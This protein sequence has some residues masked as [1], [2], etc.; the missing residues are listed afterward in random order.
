MLH[1]VCD[2][3]ATWMESSLEDGAIRLERSTQEVLKALD[4]CE[5]VFDPL[6]WIRRAKGFITI[7]ASDENDIMNAIGTQEMKHLNKLIQET[8]IRELDYE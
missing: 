1:N 6:Y 5:G 2:E 7:V 8:V 3:T 4:D